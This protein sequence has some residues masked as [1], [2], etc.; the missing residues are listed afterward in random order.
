MLVCLGWDTLT[1]TLLPI[2]V[3]E[4][5]EQGVQVLG[6]VRVNRQALV[7]ETWR[8]L[9]DINAAL[10]GILVMLVLEAV[11]KLIFVD[12]ELSAEVRSA[13]SVDVDEALES[14]LEGLQVE[15]GRGLVQLVPLSV[16]L[17]LSLAELGALG[18]TL[19]ATL[20]AL[21]AAGSGSLL[22]F[23]VSVVTIAVDVVDGQ[24]EDLQ[25]VEEEIQL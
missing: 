24:A 8:D 9:F 20:L 16:K 15:V 7:V 22:L 4:A 3:T 21:F 10:E 18:G 17:G 14:L 23:P 19:A 1:V 5:S 25:R 2:D 13:L 12:D 6:E 11:D